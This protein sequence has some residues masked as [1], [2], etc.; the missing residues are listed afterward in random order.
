MLWLWACTP[1][2]K[3]DMVLITVDT[4]RADR[5]GAYGDPLAQTPNIDAFAQQAVT[6]APTTLPAHA[7]LLTGQWPQ[8]HGA[9]DNTLSLTTKQPGLP[10]LLAGAGWATAAFVSA[11]VL[12]PSTGI[13]AGFSVYDAPSGEDAERSGEKTVAA[14]LAWWTQ[15]PSPRFLWVHL[16]DPH[17]PWPAVAGDPYRAEVTTADRAL[18][19]LLA[20]LP[21]EVVVVLAADHGESLWEH[22]ERDHGLLLHRAAT[23]VPLLLRVPGL[24]AG[25][26]AAPKTAGELNLQRPEGVDEGL[27]L[28][29]VPD[30]PRA[31]RVVEGPVSLLQVPVTLARLAGMPF[32][33]QG[34]G[35]LDADPQMAVYAE[36]W[37]P[38]VA[39]G[40]S[41]RCMVQQG[42]ERWYGP[43]HP[44]GS[45]LSVDP[46]ERQRRPPSPVLE[47]LALERGCKDLPAGSFDSTEKLRMLGYMEGAG[48]LP[49]GDF[50]ALARLYAAEA[51]ADPV[52]A[53]GLYRALV[54]EQPRLWRA[55]DGLA[56]VLAGQGRYREALELLK[57]PEIPVTSGLLAQQ[58]R[59]ALGAGEEAEALTIAQRLQ[60]EQP[61]SAEG[62]QLEV[63]LRLRQG[64]PAAMEAAALRGV[65]VAPQDPRLLF[66]LG[67]ARLRQ[68]RDAE[69]L[70]SLLAAQ[71]AGSDAPDLE[72]YIGSI[73]E[74]AGRITEALAAYGR[75][76]DQNPSE[77][78]AW[79]APAWMLYQHGNCADA[80]PLAE[81]ALRIQ[82][83]EARMLDVLAHCP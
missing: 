68:R 26:P 18:G 52:R 82:S 7:S 60:T 48:E 75:W 71:K 83:T 19:P 80:R 69:A 3:P 11:S 78:R 14:A 62:Y 56:V 13:S 81:G 1:P 70:E 55:W 59:L 25:S 65:A 74:R 28:G 20:A 33:G 22:G 61:R 79:A 53:E 24:D 45:E 38:A 35:L 10:A 29:P 67:L 54:Q 46:G 73:H 43:L 39:F 21:L 77:L 15:T 17:R 41:H 44:F 2:P 42:T 34:P 72:M 23:R 4:L 37:Y 40:W 6:S 58:G 32:S 57:N 16:Y 51:E 76:R 49:E 36:T 64:D 31:L 9:R 27:R 47:A 66:G 30:A 50:S 12:A 63:L 8:A 5:V